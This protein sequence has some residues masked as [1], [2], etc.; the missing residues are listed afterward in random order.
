MRVVDAAILARLGDP[1][2]GDAYSYFRADVGVTIR[3]GFWDARPDVSTPLVIKNPLP[4]ATYTSSVG[5]DDESTRRLSADIP[6]TSVFFSFNYVGLDRNQAKAAGERIR[7]QMKRWRPTV[8]GFSTEIVELL[9][10]Q[11]I[12]RDDEVVRPDGMPLFYGV[13]NYAVGVRQAA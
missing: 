5:D 3:D 2:V 1:V 10:S 8:A 7:A 12:R 13:D 6:R 11:R 9:E 4:Y